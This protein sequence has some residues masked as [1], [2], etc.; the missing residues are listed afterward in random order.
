MHATV[1]HQ[2]CS[3]R[4]LSGDSSDSVLTLSQFS[5]TPT[6]ITNTSDE[7]NVVVELGEGQE[8]QAPDHILMDVLFPPEQLPEEP[9]KPHPVPIEV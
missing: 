8:A 2:G 9:V 5:S 1:D 7:E 4:E 6:D 3:D